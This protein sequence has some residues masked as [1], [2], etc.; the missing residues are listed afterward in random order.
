MENTLFLTYLLPKHN[1][2]NVN[3]LKDLLWH[4]KQFYIVNESTA[5][6]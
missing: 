2:G 1:A 5:N 3:R 6:A 4:D